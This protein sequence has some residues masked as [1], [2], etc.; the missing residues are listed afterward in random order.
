MNAIDISTKNELKACEL[1]DLLQE[2]VRK[3]CEW[4]KRDFD[5]IRFVRENENKEYMEMR[6]DDED[7]MGM[8]EGDIFTFW[9]YFISEN[10]I[11]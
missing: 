7:F 11:D 2:K 5:K 9:G 3:I 4:E 10:T 6:K 8:F 1:S